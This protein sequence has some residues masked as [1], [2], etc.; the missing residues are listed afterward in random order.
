MNRHQKIAIFI[1]PFLAIG[2]YIA[3]DYYLE[4]KA[5]EEKVFQLVPEGHCDVINESCVLSAGEFKVNILDK[6]GITTVNSTFPVDD[7]V[8]FMVNAPGQYETYQLAMASTPYYW[9]SETGLAEKI[10]SKGEKQ[11]MRVI[12]SI[13]GGKYISEFY[14]QTV[15]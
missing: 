10:S 6:N 5:S 3:S 1:A 9:Q 4:H 15:K 13:K 2:G 8:L 11:K 7:A 12:V 14:T